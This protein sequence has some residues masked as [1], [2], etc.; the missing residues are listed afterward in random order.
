[1]IP[2]RVSRR[3]AVAG[4]LALLSGCATGSAS[5]LS[6]QDQSD[7][8]RIQSYLD[9][10]HGLRAHFVQSGPDDAV[11]SGTVWYDPGRLRLQYDR[12]GPMLVVASGQHLVAHRASDGMTTRIALSGNPLGL[13]LERPLRLSGEISVTNLQRT[14]GILQVS[15]ARAANPAQGLLTLIFADPPAGLDLVGLEAVDARQHR[16]R[17]RLTDGQAGLALDPGLFRPPT[18]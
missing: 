16:T 1:M 15:L 18:G 2:A 11:S 5:S 9:G 3:A 14:P 10:L 8:A 12:P 7:V 13:L 17:L 4:L 6:P